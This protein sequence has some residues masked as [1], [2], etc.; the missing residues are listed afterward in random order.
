MVTV[1]GPRQ[2]GKTTLVKTLC[3]D[4]AYINLEK[5]N[6]RELAERDPNALLNKYPDGLIIDEVQ[7]VPALLSYIQAIVDEKQKEGT[8]VVMELMKTRFN[9][10]RETNLYFYRN[11]AKKEVGVI[12]K[13]GAL[14]APIEIKS[15]QTATNRFMKET[16]YFCEMVGDRCGQPYLIYAGENEI[17]LDK[18][19]IINYQNA[20]RVIGEC[21]E[22]H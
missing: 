13:Y 18:T 14:L 6:V 22:Q 2:S 7:H 4:Y 11:S 8:M 17:K 15:A 19:D 3:K 20:S 16:D 21:D 1:T 10:G 5:P 9:K 12:Y